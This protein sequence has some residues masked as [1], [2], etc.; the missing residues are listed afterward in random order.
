MN[1]RG[2]IAETPLFV[3]RTED[4]LGGGPAFY[5]LFDAAETEAAIA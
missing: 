2:G 5:F 4:E 1:S 3:T